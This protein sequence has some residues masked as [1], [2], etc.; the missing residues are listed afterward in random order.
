MAVPT[1][2]AAGCN[3]DLLDHRFLC[4]IYLNNF[5]TLPLDLE[6]EVGRIRK[7]CPGEGGQGSFASRHLPLPAG[8]STMVAVPVSMS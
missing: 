4:V 7:T 3:D 1:S 2:V 8:L 5:L 6:F